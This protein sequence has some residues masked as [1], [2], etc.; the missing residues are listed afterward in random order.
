MNTS[1]Q[2]A[3]IFA[4]MLL[5]LVMFL[6]ILS[7]IC[8]RWIKR[9]S[10]A[11]SRNEEQ[12]DIDDIFMTDNYETDHPTT[13]YIQHSSV[14]AKQHQVILLQHGINSPQITLTNSE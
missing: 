5:L 8:W 12:A 1:S 11:R 14:V 4:L 3:L 10:N 13:T 6:Y 9:F 2:L 7:W